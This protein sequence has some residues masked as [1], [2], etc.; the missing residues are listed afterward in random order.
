[1]SR[2]QTRITA[3]ILSAC[4][5][6]MSIPMTDPVTYLLTASAAEEVTENLT[7]QSD[8]TVSGDLTLRDATIDLNGYT[9]TVTGDFK[10]PSGT[11]NI[12]TGTLNVQGDYINAVSRNNAGTGSLAMYG[13]GGKVNIGGDYFQWSSTVS[14]LTQGLMTVGG[15]FEGSKSDGEGGFD[16]YSN[17][18]VRFVGDAVH[19]VYFNTPNGYNQFRYVSMSG[20]GQLLL[21]GKTNGFTAASDLVFADGSQLSE[22]ITLSPDGHTITAAGDFTLTGAVDLRN[23]STFNVKGNLTQPAGSLAVVDGTLNVAGDY[24]NAVSRNNAGTGFLAMNWEDG[25]VIVGGDYFQWSS[26]VSSLTQGIM[27]VYGNFEGSKSGGE[28]GFDAYSGHTLAFLGGKSHEIYLNAVDGYHQINTIQ[29]GAGDAIT[30]TKELNGVANGKSVEV[31]PATLASV[32]EKTVTALTDGEGTIKFIGDSTLTRTLLIG[33]PGLPVPFDGTIAPP[34]DTPP[35]TDDEHKTDPGE[36]GLANRDAFLRIQGESFDSSTG[37]VRAA[38]TDN[39]DAAASDG[40]VL[41]WINAGDYAV[42]QHVDFGNSLPAKNVTLRFSNNSGAPSKVSI[43]AGS[44]TGQRL[45]TITLPA[46]DGWNDYRSSTIS[47]AAV[48]GLNDLYVVF[49]DGGVNLDYFQFDRTE[50]EQDITDPTD[51]PGAEYKPGDVNLDGEM[52]IMD[53]IA[54]N[55][56]LLGTS[57]LSDMAR[58][59]ADVDFNDAIDT[60]DSLLILKYVVALID[61]FGEPTVEPDPPTQD[62]PPEQEGTPLFIDYYPKTIPAGSHVLISIDTGSFDP[63]GTNAWIGIVPANVGTEETDAD[64]Y[65]ICYTY[66]TQLDEDNDLILDVPYDTQPGDYHL[67][68]YADDNGGALLDWVAVTIS[69]PNTL[70]FRDLSWGVSTEDESTPTIRFGFDYTGTISEDTYVIFYLVPADTP[71]DCESTDVAADDNWMWADEHALL[72]GPYNA[73]EGTYCL[74]GEW[75]IRAY[76]DPN[77]GRELA[78][79]AVPVYEANG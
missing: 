6:T 23:A 50:I 63:T 9:L 26:T 64:Q 47:C 35:K 65:D 12:G 40:G 71:H 77:G 20:D 17:H 10:Q 42:F 18:E 11:V 49:E 46:T 36:Q 16:A 2:F 31:E 73:F 51:P 19:E 34:S 61:S 21:R 39:P 76:T 41:G 22:G 13:E 43:Y 67:R 25:R 74:E 66:L 68:V 15:S 29:M 78:S 45:A 56:F 54:V 75:E 27:A 62:D 37:V 24:I 7:L 28:G 32:S 52:D 72:G 4:L 60:T 33:D 8:M 1:M 59:N 55:K 44:L 79:I 14:S 30:F 5:L 58:K 38:G 3:G 48:L 69:E 70:E 53:V 57:K